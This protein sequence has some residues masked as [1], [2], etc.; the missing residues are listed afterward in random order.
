M[1]SRFCVFSL[2]RVDV[3][4]FFVLFPAM[5]LNKS[6]ADEAKQFWRKCQE[7][8][9]LDLVFGEF[10]NKLQLLW[11]KIRDGSATNQE[12]L[13]AALFVKDMGLDNIESLQFDLKSE[14]PSKDN[15]CSP[16]SKRDPSTV[17]NHE[18]ESEEDASQEEKNT[19][20]SPV[21]MDTILYEVH[22]CGQSCL[23]DVDPNYSKSI[24]PLKFPILCHFQRRHAKSDYL[25][26]T[27]DV[28]YKAPCGRSLRN[29]DEVL[30]YLNQTQCRF[31]FLD[32]FSFNTYL[33]LNRKLNIGK[34]FVEDFDISDDAE[35]VPVS[36]SNE[37]DDTRPACFKYRKYTWP[38]GY[39]V[40][41]FTDLFTECC[42]CTDGCVDFMKCS[43]L[44]L[45]NR[46]YRE[47]VDASAGVSETSYKH[48]RL[49]S[50]IPTGLYECNITCK[51]D[52]K[53]CQNRVVQHGIQ[54]R[55][56][57]FK[58]KSKGWGVRCLDDIDSGT[59]VCTFAGRIFIRSLDDANFNNM[60][61]EDT[62]SYNTE[63]NDPLTRSSVI[64]NRKRL[65]S[66]SDSEIIL[67]H[68]NTYIPPTQSTLCKSESKPENNNTSTRRPL[69]CL[70]I[71]RPKTRTSVLQKRK[72][73]LIEEGACSLQN[74]SDEECLVYPILP[75]KTVNTGSV[76]QERG[77][78]EVTNPSGAALKESD[79]KD[80]D[81][82]SDG[83]TSAISGVYV[84]N[85]STCQEENE[86][87]KTPACAP[88]SVGIVHDENDYYLD[89]TK[90]GNVGRFLNHSCSPNLFVQH[91]FVETHCK[92]FPWVAFFT[93]SNF[94]RKWLQQI[95]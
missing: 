34:A 71:K 73:Q 67:M 38:R 27:L 22:I 76:S 29:F 63:G 77:A 28:I 31:L 62:A 75:K 46:T 8:G 79:E 48:K 36:F 56:Q 90:E 59:F 6:F 92:R 72:R 61:M 49:R 39:A 66:H 47:H 93:T 82:F 2:Y 40:N 16:T 14:G 58:T 78:V 91:V 55:L 85:S 33:L 7:G 52:P 20:S 1:Q 19:K 87:S 3:C 53:M 74:S 95:L 80:A 54:V 69:S 37:I 17:S 51:C 13:K 43:C 64:V 88:A 45:T 42:D 57:V 65:V 60:V 15:T 23:C 35:S 30:L 12:Y 25:S 18:E 68:S 70:S 11:Q 26:R 50:P 81:F 89:A 24:N 44:R 21:P 41:N 10:E 32:Y 86:S 94:H 4:N 9:K 84:L 5:I 83:N